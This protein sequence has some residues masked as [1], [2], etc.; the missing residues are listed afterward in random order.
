MIEM[1]CERFASSH[2]SHLNSVPQFLQESAQNLSHLYANDTPKIPG[3][4]G[5]V[6]STGLSKKNLLK[7]IQIGYD[8]RLFHPRRA[9]SR[10]RHD[11]CNSVPVHS[12]ALRI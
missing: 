6:Y 1:A 12:V 4:P 2:K 8:R 9:Y 5:A 11:I 3:L 7:L 10:F